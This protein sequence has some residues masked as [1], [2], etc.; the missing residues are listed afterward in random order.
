MRRLFG[1]AAG[2]VSVAALARL[3]GRHTTAPPADEAL[4]PD[5]ADELRQTL[6]EA[7]QTSQVVTDASDEPEPAPPES[8]E[9][10]RARVHAKAQSV[11]DA[12]REEPGP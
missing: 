3:F 9:E 5:P 2:L 11:L 1:W 10:R 8:L 12:M 7:R 4:S 6:A